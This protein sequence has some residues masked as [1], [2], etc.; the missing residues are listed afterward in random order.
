MATTRST[1]KPR[2]RDR[3]F[4]QKPHGL[5]HPRLHDLHLATA[6]VPPKDHADEAVHSWIV[7]VPPGR[8]ASTAPN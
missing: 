3:A 5:V 2:S 6:Q 4:L 8:A 1:R 7:T